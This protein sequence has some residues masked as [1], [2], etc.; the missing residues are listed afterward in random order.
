MEHKLI[1][2]GAQYLPFARSRIKALRAT[3]AKYVTQRFELPDGHVRVQVSGEHDYIFITGAGCT[4]GM[5]S[6]VVDVFGAAPASPLRYVPGILYETVASAAYN[7]PFVP[8]VP[9]VAWR[10][11]PNA[12]GQIS[13]T[14]THAKNFTGRVPYDLMPARSFSPGTLVPPGTANPADGYL[15]LKKTL[16]TLC[17]ASIFTGRCRLMVQAI[18]GK[19]LYGD[20]T[21]DS[22]GTVLTA[23]RINTLPTLQYDYTTTPALWLRA[24]NAALT[25]DPDVLVTTSTGVYL[26]PVTGKHWMFCPAYGQIRIYPLVSSAC[27][28]SLRKYLRVSSTTL[29]GADRDHLEAYVLASC[30]PNVQR[31]QTLSILPVTAYSMGYGWHW[32]WTGLTA[33]I[34][35][36]GTVDQGTSQAC[37]RSTH[38]QLNITNALSIFSAKVTVPEPA[39]DWALYRQVWCL[40]EPDWS[41]GGLLKTTPKL[42]SPFACNAPFYAFYLRD[43]LQICRVKVVLNAGDDRT[44]TAS[45]N[46]ADAGYQNAVNYTTLGMLSGF[47]EDQAGISAYYTATF[48]IGSQVVPDLDFAHVRT[49]Q[50]TDILNKQAAGPSGTAYT[51]TYYDTYEFPYGYPIGPWAYPANG[52][53]A[54]DRIL[55]FYWYR[56]IHYV[57][58]DFVINSVRVENNSVAVIVAPVNDS[59][60][61]YVTAQTSELRMLTAGQLTHFTGGQYKEESH[62]A[63]GPGGDTAIYWKYTSGRGGVGT[64]DVAGTTA[65]LPD[66]ATT[67]TPYAISKLICRAGALDATFGSTSNFFDNSVEAFSGG[68]ATTSGSAVNDGAVVISSK[69]SPVGIGFSPALPALVGWI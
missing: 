49:G 2:G 20:D 53:Y 32:N 44:R 58:Y 38:Y 43:D 7:A 23:G 64:G 54:T 26:D 17:P 69:I 10:V 30:L 50:R 65:S 33:D 39:A 12:S 63:G 52:I 60:A 61:M 6:G 37:M 57:T 55:C 21:V 13:G 1:Q 68:F 22:K 47:C 35:V 18:Y 24:H 25:G 27:G 16:V 51:N 36:N 62:G 66:A 14:V 42:T 11:N 15:A 19:P 40:A 4:F 31:K 3:G 67:T 56:T 41:T 8:K 45:T 34:V 29:L 46:F 28:E 9:P 59:E 5:D 48:T